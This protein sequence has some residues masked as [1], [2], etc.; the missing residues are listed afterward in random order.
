MPQAGAASPV[1]EGAVRASDAD[2]DRIADILRE[3]LAEGRLDA[4]EHSE[5]VEAVYSSK[6]TGELD[7]LVRDLPA[8]RPEPDPPAYDSAQYAPS[9]VPLPTEQ[10][11]AIFGEASRE[12]RW[13]VP[14]RVNGFALFGGVE[15]DLSEGI[16]EHQYVVINATAIF[17]GVE[18][19]VPENVTLR[20]KGVGVFGGFDVPTGEAPDPNAPVVLV[21]GAAVFGGVEVKTTVGRRLR[22]LLHTFHPRSDR[23]HGG[24]RLDKD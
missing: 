19:K 18:I 13:R 10:V 3:A 23:R 15:L 1:A 6:T 4:E 24:P 21:Q 7:L 8:G 9:P 20:Q 14:R 16:F 17:G 22:N 12:G 2:R 5:R 11:V